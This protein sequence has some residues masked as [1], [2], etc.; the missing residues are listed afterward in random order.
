MKQNGTLTYDDVPVIAVSS[1]KYMS[2]QMAKAKFIDSYQFLST[3]LENL[4]EILMASGGQA[5]FPHTTRYMG[6]DPILYQKGVYPYAYMTS[7]DRFEETS[8]PPRDCFFNDLTDEPLPEA[9]YARAQMTWERFGIRNLR[10]YTEH[11]LLSDVLLLADVFENF[12]KNI[13]QEHGLEC[14]SYFS[15]PGLAWDMALKLT[16]IELHLLSDPDM[17]LMIENAMRGGI[18]CVSHRLATA[19]ID[20]DLDLDTDFLCYLDQNN[21]Y[22]HSLSQSLPVRDFRF[23]TDDELT[24]FDVMTVSDESI[25]G[26]ILEVDLDYPDHL[27]QLHSSYPLAPEQ[28]EITRDMLSPY[29]AA[30]LEHMPWQ[31]CTKLAPNLYNKVKYVT[32]YRN[33]KFYLANGLVMTKVHRVLSFRQEP[34]LKKWIEYC[35]QGRQN[36]KSEFVSQLYKLY[37]NSTFGKT[38]ENIRL[39]KNMRL[40]VDPKK[41]TKAVSNPSFVSAEII[42]SDLTLVEAKRKTLFLNK[43]IYVGF[44]VLELSKLSMYEF[45]YDFL[46]KKYGPER[47]QLLYTDTDSF[48]LKIRTRDLHADFTEHADLFD[49]S[50]FDKSSPHYSCV[51]KKVVGKMKCETG[52]V[53][54]REFVALRAKMYSLLVSEDETKLTAKGIKKSYVEK[55]LTHEHYKN[56]LVN[57]RCEPAQFNMIRSRNHVL[58]TITVTKSSL[59]AFDDSSRLLQG[60]TQHKEFPR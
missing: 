27:H 43:P 34:W 39:R 41:L 17:Y 40:I 1:E 10:E 46:M 51:N 12:R 29:A 55:K 6:S 48:I 57:K 42:N 9:D 25:F 24:S 15:L 60:L 28:L 7:A 2:F 21:L 5:C 3:S 52:S 56:T 35:T 47:A 49:T 59:S 23:L 36:A 11:Y 53:L 37:A 4:V 8:L 13:Y 58:Q 19:D 18:S 30:F 38:L 16:K 44:S 20:H 45:Y 50:N 32:H 33:L 54:P 14:L 22:G 31:P 26:Y